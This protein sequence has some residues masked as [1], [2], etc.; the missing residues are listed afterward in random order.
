MSKE[1]RRSMERKRISKQDIR[2]LLC[3][4]AVFAVMLALNLL[5]HYTADDWVYMLSFSTKEPIR[6][7]RDIFPSMYVHSYRMNG[8]ILSHGL[9]QLLFL[10]PPWCFDLL[11]SAAYTL[12]MY[13]SLRLCMPGQR[14]KAWLLGFLVLGFWTLLPAFGEVAL[15][16]VGS[17]NYLWALLFG[18]IYLSPFVRYFRQSERRRTV[19][20]KIGFTVF[21]LLMGMY[22]EITSFVVLFL[23]VLL[24]LSGGKLAK[25]TWLWLPA[26]GNAAGYAVLLSMPAELGKKQGSFELSALLG[27]VGQASG[28]LLRYLWPLLVLWLLLAAWMLVRKQVNRR[29]WLS[30]IFLLGGL[31]ANYMLIAAAYMPQRCLCTAALLFLLAD[32]LL[33]PEPGG[34]VGKCFR[35]AVC[36]LLTAAALYAAYLGLPEIL[37]THRDYRAREDFIR[38]EIA[39]GYTDLT[40]PLIHSDSKY[41]L[42]RDLRDLSEYD[43]AD[44]PNSSMAKIYGV[45]SILGTNSPQKGG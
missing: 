5:T 4:A 18:L 40:L 37:R 42:Y 25:K 12:L 30:C 29:F 44:W 10:L 31:A 20:G 36:V 2:I 45:D 11:N 32:G 9:V 22:T 7:I 23:A 3:L 13:L 41:T 43:T 19:I 15:W 6:Q 28:L 21:S 27:R 16:T 8:R 26:L 35:A 33:L 17:V 1:L 38:S 34:K 14:K 39:S 24:L